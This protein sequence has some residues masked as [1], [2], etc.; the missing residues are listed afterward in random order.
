[1]IILLLVVGFSLTFNGS[2]FVLTENIFLASS[3]ICIGAG[4]GLGGDGGNIGVTDF[5]FLKNK[6]T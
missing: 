2:V 3:T 1:M 4:E 5:G 6:K